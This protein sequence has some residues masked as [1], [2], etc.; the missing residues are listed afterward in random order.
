MRHDDQCACVRCAAGW[1]ARMGFL[2]LHKQFSCVECRDPALQEALRALL[3]IK[4]LMAALHRSYDELGVM[5]AL[6]KKRMRALVV[7]LRETQDAS[8]SSCSL[9]SATSSVTPALEHCI[10]Y[11]RHHEH[12]SDPD[13]RCWASICA[14]LH[15]DVQARTLL[16]RLS[17][18]DDYDARLTSFVLGTIDW[19]V[20]ECNRRGFAVRPR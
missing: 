3:S 4:P 19:I 8:S 13:V 7:V 5:R 12:A 10:E 9:P 15:A 2:E 18:T 6:V 1:C 20:S 14:A 16:L 11:V 17:N